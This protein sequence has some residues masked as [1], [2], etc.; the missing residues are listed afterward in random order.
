[1]KKKVLYIASLCLSMSL[2]PACNDFLDQVPLDTPTTATF[3]Q[4][5]VEMNAGLT[6]AYSSIRWESATV[7]FQ[8]F[9]DHWTDIGVERNQGNAAGVFDVNNGSVSS[10]WNFAYT[11]IQRTNNLIAGMEAGKGNVPEATYNRIQAEARVLRAFAYYHLVFMY[12]DVPLITKPLA[13]EE[14][15]TQTRTP[16]AEVVS[17]LYKE[18]EEAAPALNWATQERGRLNKAVAYGLKARIAL[19]NKDYETA[20]ASA[21]LVMANA[22][23]DLNPKFQ[24]LFTTAGQKANVNKEIMF[25][26]LYSDA[27][28]NS[29]TYVPLGHGSRSLGGQSGRFPTQRLVDMFEGKDGKRIDESQVYDSSKPRLNRDK[30]LK[31]TV[32]MNGDTITENKQTAVFNIYSDKTNFLENGAWVTRTNGDFS[33]AF[34]PVKNGVGYLWAKYSFSDET[35]FTSKVSWIFMRYAEILL[36]YAE[37]KIELGQIDNTVIDA[38]NKVR[39]RAGQPNVDASIAGNQRELQELV[40]RERTVELALEGFRWFDIRRWQIAELVMPGAVYGAALNPANVP[41]TPNFKL[42]DKHDLNSIPDYTASAALRFKRD[43]R[44]FEAKHY[45]LPIPQRERDLSKTLSQ[46]TGW[47]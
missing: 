39:A 12:G 35:L 42:T 16:K 25:E 14:F 45:L 34:G 26:L 46:N 17:F 19:Y 5:E 24:D 21:Q 10:L 31:Y 33:N 9:F 44:L 38:L 41:A 43:N 2:L 36:T 11:T 13:P 1:M 22:G 23:L 40:R 27:Y 30:R 29:I 15:Y 8:V 32:V 28:T 6:G 3:L 20:A 4:T 47:N 18:L 37:A 7:P